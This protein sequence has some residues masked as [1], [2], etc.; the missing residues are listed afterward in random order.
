MQQ[1]FTHGRWVVKPGREDDFV[2][3]W[4][5]FADW[6]TANIEGSS[7]AW[8]LRDRGQPNRFFSFGPWESLEAIE[9]WRARPEFQERVGG[10]Q[11]LLE[12][13]EALTLD[14]AAEI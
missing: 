3:A 8:L 6:T 12:S 2:A 13:F 5:D 14:V 4:R 9:M 10:I 11:E 1:V 7:R